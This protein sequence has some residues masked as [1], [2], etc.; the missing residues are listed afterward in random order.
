MEPVPQTRID[1]RAGRGRVAEH[2]HGAEVGLRVFGRGGAAVGGA[3][4]GGAG[5]G[6]GE[7]AG[8]VAAGGG[9]CGLEEAGGGV[10]VGGEVRAVAGWGEEVV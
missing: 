6:G 10:E 9:S 4:E 7:G 1:A 8:G 2:V 5:A 3:G